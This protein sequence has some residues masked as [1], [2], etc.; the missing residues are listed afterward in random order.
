M[1]AQATKTVWVC[2][3]RRCIERMRGVCDEPTFCSVC[4]E[5]LQPVHLGSDGLGLVLANERLRMDDRVRIAAGPPAL[6][7]VHPAMA[8]TVRRSDWLG[9]HVRLRAEERVAG[10]EVELLVNLWETPLVLER[11]RRHLP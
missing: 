9:Q 2:T 1:S 4:Q 11:L 8:F 3:T 10:A 5:D 7:L 6:R